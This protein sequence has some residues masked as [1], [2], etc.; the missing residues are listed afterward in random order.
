[1]TA[2]KAD[3]TINDTWV[4]LVALDATLSNVD[5]LVQNKGIPRV[6]IVFG[7]GQPSGN[8]GPFLE[9]AVATVGKA[10]SIWV[11][12]PGGSGVVA[13]EIR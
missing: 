2:T 6:H 8:T 11:R 5:V 3:V 7:G 1:M 9:A 13:V 12:A 4:D 10:L